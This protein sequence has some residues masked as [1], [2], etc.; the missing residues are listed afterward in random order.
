MS[1]FLR[2]MTA[3]SKKPSD[4]PKT[5]SVPPTDSGGGHK[6]TSG[7]GQRDI[8]RPVQ[9]IDFWKISGPA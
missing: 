1:K 5:V 6:T 3:L 9:Q 7:T 8:T 4:F 2:Q